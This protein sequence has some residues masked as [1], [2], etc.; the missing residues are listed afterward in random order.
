MTVLL[1][2][3]IQK[4][5]SDPA[6]PGSTVTFLLDPNC[7]LAAGVVAIPFF[8]VCFIKQFQSLVEFSVT[9]VFGVNLRESAKYLRPTVEQSACDGGVLRFRQHLAAT[10]SQAKEW[11]DGLHQHQFA[12]CIQ[13]KLLEKLKSS[14]IVF[15]VPQI[16]FEVVQD[17]N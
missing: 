9:Q 4:L 7:K 12:S 3:L 16:E 1:P 15:A 10:F 17:D 8:P 11:V 2:I 5:L 13:E 6:Q 14:Q